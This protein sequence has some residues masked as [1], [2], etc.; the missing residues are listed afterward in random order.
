MYKLTCFCSAW[1]H[2]IKH[3]ASTPMRKIWDTNSFKHM[4]IRA[5]LLCVITVLFS[6][7]NTLICL[8]RELSP[9]DSINR[10]CGM[11]QVHRAYHCP[12]RP[13][14]HDT[15]SAR[16][17]ECYVL[18][19]T[20]CKLTLAIHDMIC[21]ACYCACFHLPLE[22]WNTM[23]LDTNELWGLWCYKTFDLVS[24]AHSTHVHKL[25]ASLSSQHIMHLLCF[26]EFCVVHLP[27]RHSL[28]C[29][30]HCHTLLCFS[31]T[32][33]TVHHM[34][35]CHQSISYDFFHIFFTFATRHIGDV[36]LAIQRRRGVTA[37]CRRCIVRQRFMITRATLLLRKDSLKKNLLIWASNLFADSRKNRSDSF[38]LIRT[39]KIWPQEAKPSG[40]SIS[41]S[42]RWRLPPCSPLGT[43]SG[44]FAVST[45]FDTC[46]VLVT[47]VDNWASWTAWRVFGVSQQ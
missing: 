33:F 22:Q 26:V 23:M 44:G 13:G 14:V 3:C 5:Q 7:S 40:W 43:C 20:W 16:W 2:V 9:I 24:N 34:M 42:G 11:Y 28:N 46:G 8:C 47:E 25:L 41:E 17:C 32:G 21:S 38:C 45:W 19:L 10:S 12:P 15:R 39:G 6:R 30:R 35:F 27:H 1:W 29:M 31:M 4:L 37:S 36:S 18:S